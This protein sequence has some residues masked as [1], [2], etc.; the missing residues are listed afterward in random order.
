MRKK[1]DGLPTAQ[2]VR[3]ILPR[4]SAQDVRTCTIGVNNPNYCSAG[5]CQRCSD[6]RDGWN[7]ARSTPIPPER[8]YPAP[9]G[10][11]RVWDWPD[12]SPDF[13]EVRPEAE[14]EG[15]KLIP[16]YTAAPLTPAEGVSE[17]ELTAFLSDIDDIGAI[18]LARNLLQKYH[19]G[20][21][22]EPECW[23]I[24]EGH[25][26]PPEA[27]NDLP[28]A[29][30]NAISCMAQAREDLI[31]QRNQALAQVEEARA[32]AIEECAAHLERCGWRYSQGFDLPASLRRLKQP[33]TEQSRG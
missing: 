13:F 1:D 20:P 19:I 22:I 2:D 11:V 15:T 30:N 26:F 17:A 6:W 12:C 23:R 10:W 27:C 21:Q 16:V 25:G 14:L 29:I 24:L 32:Q 33:S 28:S 7:A 4:S 9:F 18:G 8:E 31:T 3:G 5:H